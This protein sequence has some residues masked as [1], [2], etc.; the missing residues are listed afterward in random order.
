LA[1]SEQLAEIDL[2]N[3]NGL[4]KWVVNRNSS[5][6]GKSDQTAT[7]AIDSAQFIQNGTA[8]SR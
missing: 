8:A 7:F 2:K 5:E 1:V 4:K 3:V 6:N